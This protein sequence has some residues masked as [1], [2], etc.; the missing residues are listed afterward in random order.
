MTII[1]EDTATHPI[2]YQWSEGDYRRHLARSDCNGMLLTPWD[3]PTGTLVTFTWDRIS[4]RGFH[5]LV[6]EVNT[7]ATT[8]RHGDWGK[9]EAIAHAILHAEKRTPCEGSEPTLWSD[10]ERQLHEEAMGRMG[11]AALKCDTLTE[12]GELVAWA[13]ASA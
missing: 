2:W 13:G 12:D 8:E 10:T 5:F 11:W 1:S 7:S 6:V 3:M 4:P 9:E